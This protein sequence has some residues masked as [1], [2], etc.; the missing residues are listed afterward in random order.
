MFFLLTDLIDIY[1]LF[2]PT[3]AEYT[4]SSSLYRTFTKIDY[5]VGHKTHLNKLKKNPTIKEFLLC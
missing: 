2:H 1:R 5:T 4:I 3:A